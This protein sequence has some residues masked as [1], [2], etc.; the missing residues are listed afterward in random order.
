MYCFY[1]FK[2]KI[3]SVKCRKFSEPF[4]E[5][6]VKNSV[7]D[8]DNHPLGAFVLGIKFD[9]CTDYISTVRR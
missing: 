6:P 5:P 1:K 2:K 4:L 9:F 3:V 8:N 7:L